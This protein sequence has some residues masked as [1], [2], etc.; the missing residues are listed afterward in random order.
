MKKVETINRQEQILVESKTFRDE[1][2]EKFDVLDKIKVIPYLTDDLVVSVSQVAEFYEVTP[3]AINTVIDRN[4]SELEDD[5]IVVLKGEELKKFKEQ[6]SVPQGEEH[7]INPKTSNLTLLTKRAMLRIG[8]LLTTSDVAKK[9][10]SY[11]LNLDEIA[12]K[13]QR[14]WAIQREVGK[15]DRKRMCTAI[16]NYVPNS[17]NKIFAYPNYTNM[18]YKILFGKTAKELK[19]EKNIST[20]ELLRDSFNKDELKLIDE[21]E[22]IVTALL[23]LGFNYDYIQTQL[24]KKYAENQIIK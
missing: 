10:R 16:S 19:Q 5:G 17:K 2:V 24:K 18:I 11:L 9:V 4:R 23:S 22:T 3:K 8:M 1:Y 12:T 13:E 6:L 15:V 7:I 20:N 14:E 21:F